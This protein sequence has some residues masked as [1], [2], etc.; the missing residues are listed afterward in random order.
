[1]KN[2]LDMLFLKD[3][4]LDRLCFRNLY[5]S[6][7]K[8]SFAGFD[9]DIICEN[10]LYDKYEILKEYMSNI[11][12]Y[13]KEFKAFIK[14][15]N[16]T[17][18]IRILEDNDNKIY[19]IL[20]YTANKKEE[21]DKYDRIFFP[22]IITIPKSYDNIN[23]PIIYV[24]N[25]INIVKNEGLFSSYLGY[26]DWDYKNKCL[27]MID[28]S[29]LD[30]IITDFNGKSFTK[31]YNFKKNGGDIIRLKLSINYLDNFYYIN[32]IEKE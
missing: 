31:S 1:M 19:D 25:H 15:D 27:N 12:E 32:S 16:N 4:K 18:F 21:Y 24:D 28:V 7:N 5:Y 2:I 22:K 6:S 11:G 26:E 9:Y 29:C 3:V 8:S 13:H 23:K 20:M 10:K 14:L 17:Y 30:N